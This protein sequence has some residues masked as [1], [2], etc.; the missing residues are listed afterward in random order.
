MDAGILTPRGYLAKPYRVPGQKLVRT[1]IP[2]RKP[3][4]KAT[5]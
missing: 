3:K 4:A 2:A 1:P 5:A